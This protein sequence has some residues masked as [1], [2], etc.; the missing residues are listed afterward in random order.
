MQ[1][2]DSF[3]NHLDH[4]ATSFPATNRDIRKP[5]E[6]E[7][8]AQM[9]KRGLETPLKETYKMNRH[10]RRCVVACL[11]IVGLS[12][13]CFEDRW[14][15]EVSSNPSAVSVSAPDLFKA[16]DA[17]KAKA[18]RDYKGK[19]IEVYGLVQ[20]TWAEG[21]RTMVVLSGGKDAEVR[22]LVSPASEPDL[23]D[24][25][26][27]R[28][29]MV[30]G[31]CRGIVKGDV[32]LGGCLIV[33]SLRALKSKARAGDPQALFDLAQS[34]SKTN[35]PVHDVRR[36]FGLL[37]KA[38]EA[39]HEEA[40]DTVMQALL[41]IWKPEPNTPRIRQ[42]LREEAEGGNT[43]ACYLLG[44]LYTF[45]ADFGIDIKA[46][47]PWLQ[48][49]SDGGHQEAMFAMA[50]HHYDGVF[51]PTNMVESARLLSLIDP[52]GLP[53]SA[54]S[55]GLMTL[56]GEG[57]PR[58]IPKG[59]TLLETAVLNGRFQSATILGRIHFAGELV[60]KDDRKAIHWFL[61]GGEMGDPHGM[62][63]AGLMIG[64]SKTPSDRAK[65]RQLI[66]TALSN[67]T[68]AAYAEIFPYVAESV[69]RG[70][71]AKNPPLALNDIVK[72]R[73][74]NG[75]GIQ[76]SLRAVDEKGLT[77]VAGTNVVE[78][79]FAEIDV[80]GRTR[81]D[82]AFRQLLS[83]SII[84]ERVSG[85]VAGFTPPKPDKRSTN[86]IAKAITDM[87]QEGD[88]EAQAWL[89]NSLLESP[90]TARE[91]VEWLKKS[92]DAGCPEGQFALGVVYERG[93]GLPQDKAEALR[94]FRLAA[95][96]GH[97][98]AMLKAC[99]MLFSGEGCER[100]EV[101]GRELLE[102]AADA[103]DPTAV[104]LMGQRCI[105]GK[106]ETRDPAKA[107][108]WFRLG[109]MLGAPES[110]Y[111]LGRMYYE[112]KGVAADYNRAI[113]WLMESASQGY[114]PSVALLESDM[115]RKE[116]MARAKAAYQQE[117]QRHSARLEDIRQN[118]KYDLIL[119]TQ[120]IPSFFRESEKEAYLRFASNYMVGRF[121][122]NIPMCVAEAWD[123]VNGGGTFERQVVRAPSI[124]PSAGY[125]RG[126]N[127]RFGGSFLDVDGAMN[128]AEELNYM[129]EGWLEALQAGNY[130][131][132]VHAN[133]GRWT[134]RYNPNSR[135]FDVIQAPLFR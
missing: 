112:G 25:K 123:Y 63:M 92:A 130:S 135:T 81:C 20:E 41:G 70:L 85:L 79:P 128:R 96:Q 75:T 7:A 122:H 42:W 119:T 27:G 126:P 109:A 97:T 113:Q 62:T 120:K 50:M 116:E 72:L 12:A 99:R 45:D 80:T 46:S 29:T 67:D 124:S 57:V 114:R 6:A 100:Q 48:K 5:V 88:P 105:A 98:E 47:I 66:M 86:D 102:R 51:V 13:G 1:D 16:F 93:K 60:P 33:D 71:E 35:E 11:I 26:V 32:T 39:R 101:A 54:E 118:P 64:E 52:K 110:Q 94:L 53:R 61:K 91:G 107:F 23:A 2:G 74:A 4:T 58:D 115:A 125:P 44:M 117:L 131:G 24:L 40:V 76:G 87:A 3:I 106:T 19:V 43:E 22:C 127:N 59:L 8:Y 37:C 38:A 133:L 73:R 55:L 108:A 18:D 84:M 14:D 103:W 9:A 34:L 28:P 132:V 77:L 17:D 15:K 36:S 31:K 129:Q 69:A 65:G 121:N 56:F 78:V 89:G 10:A 82:P 111:W 30:K 21:E 134:P 90:N 95:D 68:Q 49:A 104:Y 83:R